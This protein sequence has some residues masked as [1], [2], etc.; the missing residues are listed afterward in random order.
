[1]G[2]QMYLAQCM[3]FAAAAAAALII[4]QHSLQWS[5]LYIAI[6]YGIDRLII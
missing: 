3:Y 2:G 1:M 5:E 6:M 4:R